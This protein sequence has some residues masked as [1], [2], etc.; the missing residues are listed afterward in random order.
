MSKSNYYGVTRNARVNKYKVQI[1]IAGKPRF[2]GYHEDE[3]IAAKLAEN[4]RLHL[5]DFFPK[6]PPARKFDVTGE[7][8]WAAMMRGELT[9]EKAPTYTHVPAGAESPPVEIDRLSEEVLTANSVLQNAM[10]R[11]KAALKRGAE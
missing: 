8:G 6:P 4:V 5:Q 11:L 1:F 9:K 2:F 7:T 10:Q 3:V